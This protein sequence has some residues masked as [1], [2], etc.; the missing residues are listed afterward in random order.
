MARDTA[1]DS[2]P[3]FVVDDGTYLS[4]RWPGDTHTFAALLSRKLKQA[5]PDRTA[6]KLAP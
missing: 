5:R 4:A 2:R 3:A 1:T 6:R